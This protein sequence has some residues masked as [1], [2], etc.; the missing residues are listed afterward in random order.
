MGWTISSI[1]SNHPGPLT[2]S[3]KSANMVY[4]L[5]WIRPQ[6]ALWHQGSKLGSERLFVLSK[7]NAERSVL[8]K[9]VNNLPLLFPPYH[10]MGTRSKRWP[11]WPGCV[12]GTL[13][14]AGGTC[15]R[16]GHHVKIVGSSRRSGKSSDLASLLT[17]HNSYAI[18]RRKSQVFRSL[19]RRKGLQ[20]SSNASSPTRN[21]G[22]K[23]S[24]RHQKEGNLGRF[25]VELITHKKGGSVKIIKTIK[26]FGCL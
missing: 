10:K 4:C 26:L 24:N 15:F 25:M 16:D 6:K 18:R 11:T 14:E 23:Y 22:E 3:Q 8:K 19:T 9:M 17:F 5:T 2:A 7:N 20:R 12:H 13:A 1:K 21:K